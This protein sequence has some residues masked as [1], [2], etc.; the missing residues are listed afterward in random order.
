MNFF[1]Q[2]IIFHGTKAIHSCWR[3]YT[4]FDIHI[5]PLKQVIKIYDAGAVSWKVATAAPIHS[6][7]TRLPLRRGRVASGHYASVLASVR[8]ERG[9]RAVPVQ[10]WCAITL[11]KEPHSRHFCTHKFQTIKKV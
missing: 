3:Q 1:P 4:D 7:T 2:H 6:G 5:L 8:T 10:W 11:Q 9:P